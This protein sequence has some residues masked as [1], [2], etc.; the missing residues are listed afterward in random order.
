MKFP[1]VIVCLLAISLVAPAFAQA[2]I[3]YPSIRSIGVSNVTENE[4]WVRVEVENPQP[5]TFVSVLVK[6]GREYHGDL[7]GI[8]LTERNR[9]VHVPS[10]GTVAL[11]DL[12]KSS[13]SFT[14]R[15]KG[16]GEGTTYTAQARVLGAG[17]EFRTPPWTVSEFTTL[18]SS[19]WVVFLKTWGVGVAIALGI[20]V[21]IGLFKLL[22]STYSGDDHRY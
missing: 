13:G 18:G 21:A 22:A 4:A 1:L 7:Y 5:D 10:Y 14:Y 17:G 20:A 12:P 8:S 3:P 16:L 6:G 15:L 19:G 9:T 2:P 11:K